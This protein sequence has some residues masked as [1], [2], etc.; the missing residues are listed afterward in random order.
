MAETGGR[1]TIYVRAED[2]EL[3]RRAQ[4][5]ASSQRLTMSALI[6]TALEAYLA[7]ADE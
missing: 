1:R 5:H 4:Q 3:W 7:A 6:M 2:A